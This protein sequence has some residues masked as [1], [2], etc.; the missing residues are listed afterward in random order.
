MKKKIAKKDSKVKKVEIKNIERQN[1]IATYVYKEGKLLY[2]S[3]VK[4][5]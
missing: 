5:K 2:S 4:K 3:W 1:G